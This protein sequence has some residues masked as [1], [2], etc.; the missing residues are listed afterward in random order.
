MEEGSAQENGGGPEIV[1]IPKKTYVKHV[2]G[3]E[4]TSKKTYEEEDM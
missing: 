1:E 2:G 3:F 4:E